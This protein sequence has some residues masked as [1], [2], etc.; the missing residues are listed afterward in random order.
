[1]LVWGLSVIDWAVIL[2]F[3]V[4]LLTIGLK[5]SHGVKKE[6]DFYLGGRSLGRVLQFFLQFGNSTD[7]TGAVQAAAAVYDRGAGG[8]WIGGLQTLFITPFFW[9]TQPWWRRARL[10]TMGDLFVD[11]FDSKT[12]ASIYA[13]FSVF[14][15]LLNMGLAN[16]ATYKVCTAMVL[17]APENYSAKDKAQIAMYDEYRDLKAQIAAGKRSAKE[18]RFVFLDNLA[19]R[20]QLSSSISYVRP[21]PFYATYSAIV[22]VYIVLGGL[23]AAAITDALQGL[24]ILVMSVLLIPIGLHQ[25]HGFAG[26]HMKIPE[27]VF[28]ATSSTRWYTVAAICFT[29]LLQVVGLLHNMSTGGSA[30]DEDTARFGMISGAFTKRFV[31]IAW[32]LCGLLALALLSKLSDPNEAWGA[33]SRQLLPAGLIGLMLSGM[34]LGHMPSVGVWAVSVAGLATRN[35][36]KPLFSGKS[37]AHYLRFAQ[38]SVAGVLVMAVVFALM[39]DDVINVYTM[40]LTFNSFFGAA[41]L[42]LL[43]WR[44]LT[45]VSITIGSAVWI[46]VL[47][48]IPW[49]LPL[50]S[51]FRQQPAL[52][53]T[54]SSNVAIYFDHVVRIDPQN[55]L[56]AR[57]GTGRFNIENFA[58]HC[59]GVPVETFTPA[60][61]QTVHWLLPGVF[62]FVLLIALSL[63]TKAKELERS[64][65]FFAKMRTPIAPTPEEDRQQVQ[66]SYDNP[67]RFDHQKLLGGSSWQF[68]KWSLKDAVGFFGCW[69]IVGVILWVLHFVL[70][71]GKA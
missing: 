6:S 54:T 50:F 18:E 11:R 24:L 1:M 70:S 10:M 46:V 56:S 66:L 59:A 71:I 25:V 33:L 5:A 42:L 61:F 67:H 65:R 8:I 3:L 44:R 53:A 43:F 7:S 49:G 26:L 30:K 19:L 69:V 37:E 47:I 60:G 48:I 32:M 31:L 35:V 16:L 21:L 41:V 51:S 38:W 58:L 57:E 9:F 29:S 39:A 20:G 14:G 34:L 2:A 23:R 13:A 28:D 62:P 45:P 4:L 40:M 36:Y 12:V 63:A 27:A 22:G 15:A 55:P 68:T 52:L 64:D 17:V